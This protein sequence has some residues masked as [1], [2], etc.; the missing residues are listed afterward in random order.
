[1]VTEKM[2]EAFVK[3]SSVASGDTMGCV[4]AGLEAALST[5]AEPVAWLVKRSNFD[6]I[7]FDTELSFVRPTTS[8]TCKTEM[9]PLYT[10]PP[11]PSV[12]VKALIESIIDLDVKYS[13]LN[14]EGLADWA[15]YEAG[16]DKGLKAAANALHSALSA[17]V[18]DVAGGV[19]FNMDGTYEFTDAAPAAKQAAS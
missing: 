9:V 7:L 8:R 6:G 14:C 19:R 5:D 4:R 16:I 10:A 13:R 1:M 12:A 11:A 18:Q 3:A 2:I 15:A 17:Q